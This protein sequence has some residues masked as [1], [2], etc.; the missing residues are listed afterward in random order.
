M[1][2]LLV[3]LVAIMGMLSGCAGIQVT[4]VPLKPGYFPPTRPLKEIPVV[5]GTF[6]KP[7]EELGII[8]IR[9]YPGSL[10]EEIQEK[11]REEAMMRGAHAVIKVRATKQSVFSLVPFFFSFPFSGIEAKGVAIRFLKDSPEQKVSR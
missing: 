1:R 4:Y 9:K 11:F 5:T 2:T 6:Q 7:Y 8:L 10:E 3:L